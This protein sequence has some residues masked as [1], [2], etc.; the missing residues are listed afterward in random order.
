M[1]KKV[2]EMA[3]NEGKK[4]L[5]ITRV[6]DAPRELVWKAWTDEKQIAKWWGPRG[7]TNPTCVW[8]AKPKGKISII[9]LAGKELGNFAGQK[10]PMAGTFREVTPQSRIVFVS[11]ALDDVKNI[12]IES[13]VTVDLEELGKKTKLMLH[14]VVTKVDEERA[15]FA[16][17]GMEA[18]WTQ[19]IDKLGEALAE[20][21]KAKSNI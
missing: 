1:I 12:L 17:Q 15:A 5:K 16:L 7:V 13:E 8:D 2:I 9:M 11:N 18:G 3:T 21:G 14:I 20:Q 6:F 19:S 4:D 10:W